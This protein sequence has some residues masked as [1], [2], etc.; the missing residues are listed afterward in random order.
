MPSGSREL[1]RALL[2]AEALLF[3]AGL[4]AWI[5]MAGLGAAPAGY[6]AAVGLF[7]ALA[8]RDAGRGRFGQSVWAWACALANL[9]VFP[10]LTPLG[11]G[12][13]LCLVALPEDGARALA[14]PSARPRAG[15]RV[16]WLLA[17]AAL[18]FCWSGAWTVNRYV[19]LADPA[20]GLPPLAAFAGW[21]AALLLCVLVHRAGHWLAGRW[22][23]LEVVEEW[24]SW[25]SPQPATQSSAQLPGRL[26]GWL[27][28]GPLALLV[29]ALAMLVLL[30]A[31]PAAAWAELAGLS[32]GGALALLALTLLP[33]STAGY[34]SAGARL[35]ALL[36]GGGAARRECAL[37]LLAG[38][39][40]RGVRPRNLEARWL[41]AAAWSTADPLDDLTPARA[42]AL[43]LN[44]LHAMD[45]GFEASA[46][47]WIEVLAR[48]FA[49]HRGA[50]PARWRLETAYALA[51]CSKSARVQEAPAWRSLRS[52]VARRVM[53]AVLL[54]CDVALAWARGD[55]ARAEAIARP[56]MRAALGVRQSGLAELE[57]ELLERLSPV[58]P[59]DSLAGP[60][61]AAAAAAGAG[62]RRALP[63]S[64]V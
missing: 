44:Y 14:S 37:A 2:L 43:G 51:V 26:T 50:V 5:R 40:Q 4:P 18:G 46:R 9:P 38:A 29:Y 35:L 41:R 36:R 59:V 24:S 54:R 56:A 31:R 30:I 15:M 8:A 45:Q 10:V 28:S 22:L 42:T 27:L 32:A 61:Q 1:L 49:S 57:L 25:A 21:W 47:Y 7:A 60:V 3:L 63:A 16:D 20:A 64:A 6:L 12:M 34:V 52:G 23:Q 48:D 33:W 62:G 58:P 11:C 13:A 19:R 17:A 39:W 53:P 55:Q